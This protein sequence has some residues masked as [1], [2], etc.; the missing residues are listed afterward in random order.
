MKCTVAVENP[1]DLHILRTCAERSN[2]VGF[3]LNITG[4]YF[5]NDCFMDV[6]AAKLFNSLKKPV[7]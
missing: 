3:D 6:E 4:V 7:S 5:Y 2:S 1:T